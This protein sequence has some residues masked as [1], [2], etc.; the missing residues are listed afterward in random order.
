[1]SDFYCY[2]TP[3]ARKDYFCINCNTKI[4]KGTK[5]KKY[6]G[7]YDGYFDSFRS[8]DDCNQAVNEY[9]QLADLGD[10]E[11]HM[12]LCDYVEENF[13][14]MMTWLVKDYPAVARRF[15][16]SKIKSEKR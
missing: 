15:I 2:T 13:I 6:S 11:D 5:H 4:F 12:F 10:Y 8:H 14:D 3:I 7:V 1:M 9:Y 16:E